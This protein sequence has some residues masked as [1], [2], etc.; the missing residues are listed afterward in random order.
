MDQ[1]GR[2]GGDRG[3]VQDIATFRTSE[4]ITIH[5]QIFLFKLTL[6]L[7]KEFNVK[8]NNRH[9]LF[10]FD[11]NNNIPVSKCGLCFKSH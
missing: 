9:R 3:D 6:L 11:N 1:K 7:S 5:L 2:G 10:I 4:H 8:K